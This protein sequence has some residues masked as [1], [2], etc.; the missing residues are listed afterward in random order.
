MFI[1]RFTEFT[2]SKKGT[3]G[4]GQSSTDFFLQGRGVQVYHQGHPRQ[5]AITESIIHDLI[6]SCNLPLSLIEQPGFR[7]FMAV[8]DE[9]YCPVSRATVTQNL[10][11][12]AAEKEAKIKSKL[13]KTDTV[14]VTVDIWTDRV[15]QGSLGITA[16]FMELDYSTPS[17]QSVLL[18]CER[19]TG[20][21]TGERIS[22]KFEDV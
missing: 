18:A 19:F 15:M 21:H 13:E 16:H 3:T 17:L 14:S 7:N 8:V 20:S 10:S 22:E 4:Q 2:K 1:Y 11:E 12:Q 6:I 9:K 5:K